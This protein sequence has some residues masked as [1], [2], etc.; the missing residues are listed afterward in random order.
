MSINLEVP[1]KFKPLI[2]QAHLVAV[3]IFRA[4]SRKYDQAEHTYPKELDMLAAVMEGMAES[5]ALGGA[6]ALGGRPIAAVRSAY[7][8]DARAA[9]RAPFV[10]AVDDG[11][12]HVEFLGV[13]VLVPVVLARVGAEDLARH[14]VRLADQE[15][16]PPGNLK[17]DHTT[18]APS[19]TPAARRWRY[20]R[21]TGCSLT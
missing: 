1:R 7:R 6:G 19:I 21:S 12:E 4:N 15:L 2:D 5:G 3:E 20:Q 14:P 10:H 8:P 18:R 9:Q 16:E 11:S 17:V 13:R